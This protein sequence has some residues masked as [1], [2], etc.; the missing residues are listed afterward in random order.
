MPAVSAR[1]L[2]GEASKRVEALLTINLSGST[3]PSVDD[4]LETYSAL[5]DRLEGAIED[6]A[7]ASATTKR[8]RGELL[9]S[10]R[11]AR[12]LVEQVL[13]PRLLVQERVL[14]AI[15]RLEELGPVSALIDQA[16]GA[17]AEAVNLERV[18]LYRIDDGYLVVD[19]LYSRSDPVQAGADLLRLQASPVRLAYPLVEAE[20]VRRRRALLVESGDGDPQTRQ[21]N[22]EIMRWRGYVAA[23]IVVT[24]RVVGFFEGDRPAGP[25]PLSAIDREALDLFARRFAQIFERAALRRRLRIQQHEMR[26][27]ASWADSRTSELSDRAIDLASERSPTDGDTAPS[28]QATTDGALA[29]LLTRREIDVLKLMVKGETNAGIAR[30]LVISEGTVKFHVKNVLRKMQASNRADASSRYLR[31]TLGSAPLGPPDAER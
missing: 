5:S 24:G 19:S 10:Q 6:L 18:L 2:L 26:R 27:V 14:A 17:A 31:L 8:R 25:E 3:P 15:E 12:S 20:I 22:Y 7:Q 16:P 23:P 4:V 9:E 21:A 28:S 13:A 30:A 1:T 29:D 11:L